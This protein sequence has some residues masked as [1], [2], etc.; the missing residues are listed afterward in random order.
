MA[1]EP[2]TP[3]EPGTAQDP[4]VAGTPAAPPA[5]A[6]PT[7]GLDVTIPGGA[8][9]VGTDDDGNPRWVNSEGE[10]IKAPKGK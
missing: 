1:D 2:K 8:Y 3:P 5:K 10:P 6:P 7:P 4:A 9:V